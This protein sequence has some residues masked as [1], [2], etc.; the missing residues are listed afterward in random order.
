MV[1]IKYR[2]FDEL[3]KEMRYPSKIIFMEYGYNLIFGEGR[4]SGD[5]SLYN[6]FLSEPMQ[7]IGWN[8]KNKKEIFLHDIVKIKFID[9]VIR[10]LPKDEQW[11]HAVII[12]SPRMLAYTLATDIEP[13]KAGQ[14]EFLMFDPRTI[15]V[16]GNWYEN[17]DLRYKV[18]K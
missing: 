9:K 1:S 16:I 13:D 10:D 8:D 2:V 3:T 15:E 6:G 12:Y 7:Y 11:I 18:R 5:Q 17:P 14:F 4:S